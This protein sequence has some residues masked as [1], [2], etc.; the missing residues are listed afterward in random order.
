MST[1]VVDSYSSPLTSDLTQTCPELT[2]VLMNIHEYISVEEKFW[3]SSL[4]ENIWFLNFSVTLYCTT[5]FLWQLQACD[6]WHPNNEQR[7]VVV[8]ELI[9][10][11]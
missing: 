3:F 11:M 2:P 1:Q 6:R 4:E 5:V 9:P 8:T 10:D 7:A